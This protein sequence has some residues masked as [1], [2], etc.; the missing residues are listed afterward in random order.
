[1]SGHALVSCAAV[2]A[3]SL[4]RAETDQVQPLHRACS[5]HGNRFA[6]MLP[7]KEAEEAV[8]AFLPRLGIGSVR[9]G[10]RRP[11]DHFNGWWSKSESGMGFSS[12]IC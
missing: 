5:P 12:S 3:V 1:M 8:S 7:G 4:Q 2:P 9:E 10:F 11:L 6:A